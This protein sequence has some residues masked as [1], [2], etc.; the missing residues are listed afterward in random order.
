VASNGLSEGS[1]TVDPEITEYEFTYQYLDLDGDG[2]IS[3][4]DTLVIDNLM[5]GVKV[6][7]YDTW[8]DQYTSDSYATSQVPGFGA[9]L[10][11]LGLLGAALAGR[12]D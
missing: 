10:G 1:A 11:T 6:E 2:L 7:L 8:A 3:D 9:L 12:R 5:P 4:M